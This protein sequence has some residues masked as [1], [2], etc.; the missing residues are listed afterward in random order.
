MALLNAQLPRRRCLIALDSASQ[1]FAVI[2]L[3]VSRALYTGRPHRVVIPCGLGSNGSGCCSSGS[4]YRDEAVHKAF[5]P[6]GLPPLENARLEQAPAAHGPLDLWRRLLGTALSFARLAAGVLAVAVATLLLPRS[7]HASGRELSAAAAAAPTAA[8]TATPHDHHRHRPSCSPRTLHQS[9]SHSCFASA[10]LAASLRHT[11]HP[12]THAATG[13]GSSSQP[14]AASVTPLA[15]LAA[16]TE[17]QYTAAPV[18]APSSATATSTSPPHHN[19]HNPAT[20]SAASTDPLAAAVAGDDPSAA[21]AVAQ[22]AT[23]LGVT[24][25][26]AAVVRLYEQTRGSV[27]C[28]SAMRAMA[29]LSS[30]D[31]GRLPAGQGSGVLWGDKGHVVT[32]HHLVKGAGEVKVGRQGGRPPGEVK[33]EWS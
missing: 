26:E 31:L 16:A 30:L 5:L 15:E 28:V 12:S 18:P 24:P 11:P 7:A 1:P 32:A 17:P 3:A 27:V 33:I 23:S 6:Q 2:P 13:G 29:S 25:T 19:S 9:K 8:A 4:A 14:Q 22:L 21:A 20:A 10:S